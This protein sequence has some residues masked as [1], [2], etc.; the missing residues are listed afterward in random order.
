MVKPRLVPAA[1]ALVALVALVSAC[2]GGDADHNAQDVNFARNMV[3]HHE[4]AV[5]MSDLALARA[6]N[7]QVKD[8][9]TRI[10]AAQAPEINLMRGWLTSWDAGEA[11]HGGHSSDTGG[12]SMGGGDDRMRGMV[13]GPTMMQLGAAS[14]QEFDRLFLQSMIA[15]HQGAVEM[16]KIQL[17]DG[18]F[19]PAKQLANQ[20]ITSQEKEIAEMGQLLRAVP[21]AAP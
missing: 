14:G 1:V 15:H 4:Q 12:M 11:D 16:A 10:K 6:A 8:L 19:E 18:R 13:D 9:A 21:A 5:T 7:P 17:E 3:P 2:G 20:V